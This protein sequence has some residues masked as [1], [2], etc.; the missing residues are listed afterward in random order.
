MKQIKKILVPTDFS[1][2]AAKAFDFACQ[3]AK[4]FDAAIKL[5]HVYRSDFGMPVPESM[6]YQM[7]EARKDDALRKMETFLKSKDLAIKIES[8]VEMGFPSDLLSD[9][10]KSKDESIDLVVMGTKGEH[11]LAERILGSVTS[12]VIRDAACPVLAVPEYCKDLNIKEIAYAS[13][14]KTDQAA[15]FAEA[16]EI[17]A[18]FGAVLNCVSVDIN[19][20]ET[21]NEKRKFNEIISK[22]K[23]DIRLTEIKSDTLLHGLEIYVQEN[24]ID[25]LLM[26]RPQRSLFERVFHSSVT[27]K[28]ALHST[29]P[30]LVFKK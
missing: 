20:D 25:M 14:L 19:G 10:T 2:S 21:D 30:L 12:A 22:L 6:A 26:C 13:D 7:L 27:K 9:Y 11:N 29:V 15:S 28:V 16:A 18:L 8:N 4:K 17:A 24:G 3:L 1:A 5:I 23:L